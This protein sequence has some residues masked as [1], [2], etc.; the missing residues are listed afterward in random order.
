MLHIV[1]VSCKPNLYGE[2]KFRNKRL[3]RF[4]SHCMSK[5][6]SRIQ[7]IKFLQI[8]ILKLDF[9]RCFPHNADLQ[10]WSQIWS[11]SW[12]WT[13]TQV[14]SKKRETSLKDVAIRCVRSKNA[15]CTVPVAYVRTINSALQMHLLYYADTIVRLPNDANQARAY[16][17]TK[18]VRRLGCSAGKVAVSRFRPPPVTAKSRRNW[19]T[20][21]RILIPSFK[22]QSYFPYFHLLFSPFYL[23]ISIL[24]LIFHYFLS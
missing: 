3:K 11:C 6:N 19:K 21:S 4:A 20:P 24:V 10:I 17:R 12:N 5:H 23:F 2:N 15:Q 9:Q 7:S 13:K 18:T 14:R 16:L 8:S 22:P 1:K